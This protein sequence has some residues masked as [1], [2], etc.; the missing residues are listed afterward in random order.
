VKEAIDIE[1]LL[2]WA[3]RDVQVDQWAERKNFGVKLRL[4]STWAAVEHLGAYGT[5]IE[6]SNYEP[7][8]GDLD[9]AALIHRTVL[10]LDD[11]F[12][13]SSDDGLAV[14]DRALIADEGGS[15]DESSGRPRLIMPGREP[16][17]VEKVVV[18]VYLVLHAR[19]AT[20]PDSY[21]DV[22]RRR[23]RPRKDGE[24]AAGIS[25]DDV[26]HHRAVY[27]VWH[28][29]LGILAA[30]LAGRLAKWEPQAPKADESPWLRPP[31]RIL[32]AENTKNRTP[33][34]PLKKRRKRQA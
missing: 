30:E 4:A 2:V 27:S 17:V 10:G 20:R 26:M 11:A 3:Y 33:P 12:L 1:D 15:I 8:L 7:E 19:Q 13:S 21:S 34:K 14:W 31:P 28:A 25:F 16:L 18:S 24:I 22:T 9:D 29:A 5:F 6:R 23:G 32:T